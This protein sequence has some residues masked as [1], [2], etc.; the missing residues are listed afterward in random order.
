MKVT[1][2]AFLRSVHLKL[3]ISFFEQLFL[4]IHRRQRWSHRRIQFQRGLRRSRIT[5]DASHRRSQT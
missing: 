3:V 1:L 5:C 2:L 4:R